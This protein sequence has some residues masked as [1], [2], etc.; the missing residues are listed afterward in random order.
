MWLA[1]G[2]ANR[3]SATP[4]LHTR[5]VRGNTALLPQS[6]L[7][8]SHTSNYRTIYVSLLRTTIKYKNHLIGFGTKN[9]LLTK[10]IKRY[11]KPHNLHQ[12]FTQ[13]DIKSPERNIIFS[14]THEHEERRRRTPAHTQTHHYAHSHRLADSQLTN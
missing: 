3:S 1:V 6:N 13:Y 14:L 7:T 10:T 8:F 2:E 11:G 12:L 4:T 5:G 9:K